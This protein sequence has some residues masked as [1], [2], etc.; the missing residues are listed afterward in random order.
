VLLQ[1][2]QLL[3]FAANVVPVRVFTVAGGPLQLLQ[4]LQLAA[5]VVPVR[6][7]TVAGGPLQLLQLL[8]LAPGRVVNGGRVA[9]ISRPCGLPL[10]STR[11]PAPWSGQGQHRRSPRG[12][13]GTAAVLLQL[14]QLL[15]LAANVVP[16]RVFT[17][18]GGLLPL[19]QLL[20]LA[21][22]RW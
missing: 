5:N 19:L 9:S 14:L 1:L 6:V 22:D 10:P 7:F 18:A 13:A 11:R 12:S 8:Q 4:L 3:Q 20:Q 16:V 15:Q 2:L 17:V 21:P